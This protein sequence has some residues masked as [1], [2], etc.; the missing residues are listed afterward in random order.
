[1]DKVLVILPDNNKGKYI[2]K[3]YANAFK[4]FGFFVNERKIY[5][6]CVEDIKKMAPSLVFTFW[7]D[8]ANNETLIDFFSSLEL[9]DAVFVNCSEQ[10][11]D[12]P[13]K[14]HKKTYCF[15]SDSEKTKYKLLLGVNA[16]E[17][18]TK[19][20]S[21]KYSITF[22]GNPAYPNREKILSALIYNFG[23]INIFACSYDFYKSVDEISASKLLS[24]EYLELYRASYRG[25]VENQKELSEIFVSSKINIDM[26][27]PNKKHL[28]YRFFEILA[29]G[30]F[31]LSHYDEASLYNFEEGK[32][33]DSYDNETDLIDKVNF[34]IKN[35]NIAQS[36]AYNGR[37]HVASNH[38]FYDRLKKIL[39]VVYGEDFSNR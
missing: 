5:D 7:S 24:D 22:A 18:R 1:M 16:K 11:S 23:Q 20:K 3:S 34:Y 31:L 25:Y 21:Y 39:K 33:F 15:S 13:K 28:N 14:F 17:Y 6:L 8:M 10:L 4:D 26:Q 35:A 29:S 12:I 19:F 27:N 30:G 36:I 37:K 38:S 2:S 32:D 9:P